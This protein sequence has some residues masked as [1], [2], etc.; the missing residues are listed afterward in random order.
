V[1]SGE[2]EV[3][4]V[5]DVDPGFGSAG[6]VF[7]EA[8]M[9]RGIA[10]TDGRAKSLLLVEQ[11]LGRRKITNDVVRTNRPDLETPM[12]YAIRVQNFGHYWQTQSLP[13]AEALH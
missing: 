11:D 5:V 2:A 13:A 10:S 4:L 3:G 12:T 1:F 6:I 8:I 9:V 7:E